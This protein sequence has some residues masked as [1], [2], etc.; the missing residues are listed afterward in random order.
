MRDATGNSPGASV[1]KIPAL[2]V[3]QSVNRAP[4]LLNA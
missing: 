1:V 2:Q 3:S 4:Y